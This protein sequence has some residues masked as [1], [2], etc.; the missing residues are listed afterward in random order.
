MIILRGSYNLNQKDTRF[1]QA[2]WTLTAA[3]C[4]LTQSHIMESQPAWAST[5]CCCG[6]GGGGPRLS[7]PIAGV[8]EGGA[9][10]R[11]RIIGEYCESCVGQPMP[12]RP[13]NSLR[14]A[15]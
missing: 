10:A 14:K 1:L 8:L 12:I 4:L 11:P 2:T 13:A 6:G 3:Y 9:R 15:V 5:D 7:Q